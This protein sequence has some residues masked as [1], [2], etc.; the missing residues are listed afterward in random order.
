MVMLLFVAAFAAIL[1]LGPPTW[2]TFF[3]AVVVLLGGDYVTGK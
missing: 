1:V 2:G 3:L